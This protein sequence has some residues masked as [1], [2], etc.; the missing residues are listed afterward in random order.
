MVFQFLILGYL[1]EQE[2]YELHVRHD[3]QFL[4]LGYGYNQ[5]ERLIVYELSIPHFRIRDPVVHCGFDTET[6]T[7]NSSF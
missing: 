5:L 6:Y 1:V 4:I 3:F 7:F 2:G